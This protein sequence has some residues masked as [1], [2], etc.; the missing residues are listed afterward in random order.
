[1]RYSKQVFFM[2][3]TICFMD[4]YLI[5]ICAYI[6]QSLEVQEDKSEVFGQIVKLRQ[7]NKY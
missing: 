1:M 7:L 2:G 4:N 5:G 3:W 6:H